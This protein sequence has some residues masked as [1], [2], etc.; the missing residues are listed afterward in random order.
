MWKREW[1]RME[2]L[3]RT[4]HPWLRVEWKTSAAPSMTRVYIN[5]RARGIRR[6]PGTENITI[7]RWTKIH[8]I[9]RLTYEAMCLWRAASPQR[10]N[11]SSN[12]QRRISSA[13]DLFVRTVMIN[14]YVPRW[15]KKTLSHLWRG[16]GV[17]NNDTGNK[18]IKKSKNW[19]KRAFIG[20]N[21]AFV[22]KTINEIGDRRDF[23]S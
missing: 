18:R 15:E 4:H 8:L 13:F 20:G 19:K 11:I 6:V 10:Q 22:E 3:A 9:V 2:S 21:V 12:Y 7:Q 1:V 23:I 5:A 14:K 16:E 17:F